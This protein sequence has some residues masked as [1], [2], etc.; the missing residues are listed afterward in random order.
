MS[1]GSIGGPPAN[2]YFPAPPI[3]AGS[4]KHETGPDHDGDSDDAGTKSAAPAPTSFSGI[5]QLLNIRA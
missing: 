2:H 4:E 1:I 5:G 3:S